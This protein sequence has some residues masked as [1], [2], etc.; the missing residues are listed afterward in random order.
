MCGIHCNTLIYHT[1]IVHKELAP[2]IIINRRDE[3]CNENKEYSRL[4]FTVF[5]YLKWLQ[6]Y[7][8]KQATAKHHSPC[9]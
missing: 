7:G 6:H 3:F 4:L 9:V 8:S 2:P 1:D 5:T